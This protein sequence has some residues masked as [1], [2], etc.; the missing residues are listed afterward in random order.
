ME[1]LVEHYSK[2]YARGK[3]LTEDAL[4]AIE[5]LAMLKELD[6]EQT[7][8]NLARLWACLPLAK[9]QAKT[10]FPLRSRS[11]KKSS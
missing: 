9:H 10:A 3:V 2:L 6:R 1:R 5:C 11:A 7:K 4:Y 8:K